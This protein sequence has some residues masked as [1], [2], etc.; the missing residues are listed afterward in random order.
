MTGLQV[1]GLSHVT[2]H[3]RDLALFRPMRKKLKSRTVVELPALVQVFM[4]RNVRLG[5]EDSLETA[6]AAL[7][8]FRSCE[9]VFEHV[10]YNGA[11]PC[12]L[13]PTSFA[14]YYE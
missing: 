11:W 12:D 6:R 7:D 14:A 8:L 1:L 5:Y 4:G 3:T 10:I 9:R 2:L 13:P